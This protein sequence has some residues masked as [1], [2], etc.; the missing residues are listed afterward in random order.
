M[1]NNLPELMKFYK[2]KKVFVTGD[3]GFKGTW[4]CKLLTMAQAEVTGYALPP[5]SKEMADVFRW[6]GVAGRIR[7]ID[8]DVRDY[9]ALKNAFE[10]AAPEIVF[11]LAAQSLVLKSYENPLETYAVNV[12][13]TANLLECARHSKSVRSLLNVTTDKV[14]ENNEWCW[15]YR[16]TDVLNGY[17]PYSNSKSCSELVTSSYR[18]SFLHPVG[19]AVSTARAGNVIGGGDFAEN[20]IIPDCIRA[21][22]SGR[23]IAI[24]S[25]HSVRPYQHVLE[26]LSA[27]LL[28]AGLYLFTDNAF[29]FATPKVLFLPMIAVVLL[30]HGAACWNKIVSS[31]Y[32]GGNSPNISL[33]GK[34]SSI[35]YYG[36]S[37]S[38]SFLKEKRLT[39]SLNTS[40][41]FHKYLTFKNET[42]T[43][44][45]RSW[46]KTKLQQQSYGLNI[47]WRFGELKTQVKKANRTIINDDLMSGGNEQN[48]TGNVQ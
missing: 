1:M 24:R 48:N 32:G 14:Y 38:R 9:T 16:E 5:A 7:H 4:L 17:D 29:G 26:P 44:T 37:L 18:K 21:A 2:G 22:T 8:G 33:Q 41:L 46:N 13:G 6:S 34:G 31:L 36:F 15:G 11:H 12:M 23:E 30:L 20:R 42:V 27:Y 40:N 47:S 19:I 3:T 43:D 10:T 45:F 35:S 28:L 25:P 39:V